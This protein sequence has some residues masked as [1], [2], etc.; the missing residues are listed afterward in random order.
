MSS[1]FKDG[2][3]YGFILEKL[4]LRSGVE[5]MNSTERFSFNSDVRARIQALISALTVGCCGS[6]KVYCPIRDTEGMNMGITGKCIP[7]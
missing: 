2:F 3:H 1:G 4:R 5:E 7:N 6:N